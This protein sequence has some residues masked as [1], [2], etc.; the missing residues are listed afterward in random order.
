MAVGGGGG[1]IAGGSLAVWLRRRGHDDANHLMLIGANLSALAFGCIMTQIDN[2]GWG[3]VCYFCFM[4]TCCSP[5]GGIIASL[6]EIS[7]NQMRAQVSAV[8]QLGV[9]LAGIGCGPTLVALMSQH[10][11]GGDL[12]LRHAVSVIVLVGAPTAAL[13]AWLARPCHRRAVAAG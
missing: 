13:M 12:G 8:Y 3:F 1:I 11:F 6:Q 7:P 5:V 9:N 2:P 4:F 10:V